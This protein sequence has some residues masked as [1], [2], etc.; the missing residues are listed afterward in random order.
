M[1]FNSGFKGLS[2]PFCAAPNQQLK[3]SVQYLGQNS[4]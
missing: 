1:G 4:F 2:I 3:G